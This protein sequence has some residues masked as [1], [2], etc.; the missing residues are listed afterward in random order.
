MHYLSTRDRTLHFTAAE[1]IKQGL[2]RDGGLFL[3]EMLP[4]LS[5]RQIK[6]MESMSCLLY[7]SR[8]AQILSRPHRFWLPFPSPHS[9]SGGNRRSTALF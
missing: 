2:S 3:P 7:T 5:A 9:R 8:Q 1:A 6:A 4:A